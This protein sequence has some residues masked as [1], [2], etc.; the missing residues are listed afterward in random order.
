MGP[1][2]NNYTY[3]F[4]DFL[5]REL[6]GLACC[7]GHQCSRHSVFHLSDGEGGDEDKDGHCYQAMYGQR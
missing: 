2:V 5:F 3:L 6:K 7:L 1:C 4:L